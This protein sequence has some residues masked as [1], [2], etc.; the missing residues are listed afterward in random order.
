MI[1]LTCCIIALLR[2]RWPQIRSAAALASNE[3]WL[4]PSDTVP[5]A[6]I[7]PQPQSRLP[8]FPRISWPQ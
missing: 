1:F 7:Q 3:R 5:V 2:S 4:F 6:T 8:T